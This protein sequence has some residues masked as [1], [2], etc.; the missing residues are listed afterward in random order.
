MPY[1]LP[2]RRRKPDFAISL[3]NPVVHLLKVGA[4]RHTVWSP[5]LNPRLIPY[6]SGR[7]FAL[8]S[9]SRRKYDQEFG[10][11]YVMRLC[12][13]SSDIRH[14]LTHYPNWHEQ[15][16]RCGLW[17]W[18]DAIIPIEEASLSAS[19]SALERYGRYALRW[20]VHRHVDFPMWVRSYTIK[21]LD[22]A[23]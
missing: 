19:E 13:G 17:A 16:G 22:A 23:R 5:L 2:S 20:R 10:R 8:C 4:I 12:E 6:L 11:D 21:A 14:T 15:M 1:H 7:L 18:L 9:E 3:R